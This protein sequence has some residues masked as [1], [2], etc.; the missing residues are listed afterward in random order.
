MLDIQ[1]VGPVAEPDRRDLARRIADAA[2]A[3]FAS[4]PGETWVTLHIVAPEAYAENG[5]GPPVG[6]QLV[7]VSILQASPPT[8]PALANQAAQLTRAI[9]HACGRPPGNVHLVYQPNAKGRVAF[10]GRLVE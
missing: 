5:G 1:L 10:G 8:G 9:A 6:V 7:I 2:G 4:P 3:V